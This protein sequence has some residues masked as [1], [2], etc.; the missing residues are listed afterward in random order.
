MEWIDWPTVITGVVTAAI[1]GLLAALTKLPARLY[2]WHKNR[3]LEAIAKCRTEGAAIRNA[4]LQA[5]APE[6][7]QEWKAK[8]QK[9]EKNA[10]KKVGKF[11]RAEGGKLATLDRV[12]IVGVP[13]V[14]DREQLRLIRNVTETLKQ[15][16]DL[17]S[18]NLPRKP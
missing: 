10:A 13:G 17:L 6:P 18:R 16:G 11:S 2:E 8:A 9:W 1:I 14:N 5:L 7:L 3:Q 4:G 12:P 15:L